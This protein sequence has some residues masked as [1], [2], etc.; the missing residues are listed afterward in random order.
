MTVGVVALSKCQ[1]NILLG[2]KSVVH[3]WTMTF[4]RLKIATFCATDK[5]TRKFDL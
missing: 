2:E 5:C 3:V 4:E 1:L